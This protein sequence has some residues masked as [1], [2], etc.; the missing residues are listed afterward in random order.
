MANSEKSELVGRNTMLD[1]V[2]QI[3]SNSI[4]YL[5]NQAN[6]INAFKNPQVNCTRFVIAPREYLRCTQ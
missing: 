4:E 5:A 1:K 3:K 6:R 2:I